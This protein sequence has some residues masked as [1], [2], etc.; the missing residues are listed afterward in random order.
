MKT[1]PFV[2]IAA[3]LASSVAAAPP[4][5]RAQRRAAAVYKVCPDPSAPCKSPDKEFAPYELSFA[6]PKKLKPNADYT[7]A[8]FQAVLLKTFTYTAD[9]EC[10]Q[11]EYSS[12]IERER[13]EV[14]KMFPERKVFADHQCPDLSSVA[15]VIAGQPK[16]TGPGPFLAVYGGETRAEAEQVLRKVQANYPGAAIK[17]M[18]VSFSI[19]E[20]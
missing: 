12:F 18:Q 19:I 17:T 7:S 11:G 15:Y 6:L 3:L 1:R 13:E 2:I 16:D 5:Q 8:S 9:N 10:D 14:Q 4:G 20:Q